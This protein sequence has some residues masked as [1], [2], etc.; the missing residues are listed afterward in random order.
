MKFPFVSVV[1]HL[2]VVL[3]RD[4]TGIE[5]YT[6]MIHIYYRSRSWY[7][8]ISWLCGWTTSRYGSHYAVHST[9]VTPAPPP[10]PPQ[11]TAHTARFH[12]HNGTLSRVRECSSTSTTDH[13][14][15]TLPSPPAR[16]L[17]T[18]PEV[19]AVNQRP[20]K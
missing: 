8:R 19:A 15:T 6:I 20:H 3:V 13:H 18:P 7:P 5:N 1:C 9:R 2:R 12:T 16:R 10:P 17:A 4:I 11:G 14:H